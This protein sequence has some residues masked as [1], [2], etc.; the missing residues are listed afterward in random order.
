MLSVAPADD[1]PSPKLSSVG[2]GQQE[3][4]ASGFNQ[5]MDFVQENRQ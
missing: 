5:A 2:T 4:H 1:A 3:A